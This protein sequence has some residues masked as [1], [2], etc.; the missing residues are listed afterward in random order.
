M[1]SLSPGSDPGKTTSGLTLSEREREDLEKAKKRL[2]AIGK[3]LFSLEQW[4]STGR[5][6]APKGTPGNIWPCLEILSVLTLEGRL[7]LVS[8][9]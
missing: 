9:G 8:C 2:C 7:F 5:G 3:G 6:F 4:C 1:S